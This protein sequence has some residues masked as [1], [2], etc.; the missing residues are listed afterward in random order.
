MKYFNINSLY[1]ISKP[2]SLSPLS[3]VWQVRFTIPIVLYTI[4]A[5]NHAAA[6]CSEIFLLFNWKYIFYGYHP[7]IPI[8]PFTIKTF[9]IFNLIYCFLSVTSSPLPVVVCIFWQILFRFLYSR[10]IHHLA[11]GRNLFFPMLEC[12]SVVCIFPFSLFCIQSSYTDVDSTI[13]LLWIMI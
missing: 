3:V 12:C 8:C 5:Y 2:D 11:A 9:L 10:T 7:L 4:T 6:T 1:R 13:W